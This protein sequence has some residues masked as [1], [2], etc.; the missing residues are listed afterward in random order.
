MSKGGTE[1]ILIN[2]MFP[3]LTLKE[4]E[5]YS[6]QMQLPGFGEEAQQKLKNSTALVTGVGGLGGTAALYLAVAGIGKL[7]LIA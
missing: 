7:I 4:L 2:A 6:R 5:R 3:N 1:Q